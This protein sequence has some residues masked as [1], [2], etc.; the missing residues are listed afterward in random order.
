[1]PQLNCLVENSNETIPRTVG[2]P[3]HIHC[4]GEIP[5]LNKNQIELRIEKQDKYKLK[6]LQFEQKEP[7]QFDLMV[8]SYVAGTHQ[9]KALQIVDSEHSLVLGDLQFTIGSV[10]NPEQPQQEP[11]PAFGPFQIMMPW[12]Y[13]VLWILFFLLMGGMVFFKFKRFRQRKKLIQEIEEQGQALSPFHQMTQNLRIWNRNFSFSQKN[14]LNQLFNQLEKYYRLYL[15]RC[16]LVPTLQWGDSLII[17][18]LKKR[19]PQ[20]FKQFGEEIQTIFNELSLAR[21]LVES[22]EK[23]LKDQDLH[24]L[25]EMI[26]KNVDQIYVFQKEQNKNRGSS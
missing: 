12:W 8:T 11:Y 19:H 23:T 25:F 13:F 18:D 1:M 2:T 21:Q 3:F 15:G 17:K 14:D 7:N 4:Q 26:Q 5:L 9:L 24:Q 6:I 10:L 22:K 20:L 16:F